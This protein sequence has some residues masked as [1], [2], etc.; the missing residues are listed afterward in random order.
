MTEAGR[1]E[2]MTGENT[3]MDGEN[4]HACEVPVYTWYFQSTGSRV[5]WVGE[6][7]RPGV[8]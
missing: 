5:A 3:T 6:T 2:Y 4:I 1:K 7:P 8:S